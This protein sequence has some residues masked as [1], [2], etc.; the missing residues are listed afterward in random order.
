M[1][2]PIHSTVPVLTE[3]FHLLQP[4]SIGADRLREFI[5]RGG[6]DI[7]FLDQDRLTRMFELMESYADHP[8]D[9]ADASLVVA[10]E[11]LVTR[12]IFTIDRSDFQTYRIR[13]GHRY[14]PFEIVS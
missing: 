11:T 5:L 13:H 7:W 2:E 6:T 10:A 1:R 9:L 3:A 4:Q 8:M 14:Y 12:K